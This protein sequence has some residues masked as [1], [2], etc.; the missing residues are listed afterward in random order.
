[1][2]L[3]KKPAATDPGRIGNDAAKWSSVEA[4]R[5]AFRGDPL[6]HDVITLGAAQNAQQIAERCRAAAGELRVPTL[7]LHGAED[8]VAAALDSRAF[9]GERVEFRELE[10]PGTIAGNDPDSVAGEIVAWLDRSWR[11]TAPS[12]APRAA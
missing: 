11:G 12:L 6:V 3:F 9:R 7:L 4:E 10:G 5:A 1:M 8:Q 2:K